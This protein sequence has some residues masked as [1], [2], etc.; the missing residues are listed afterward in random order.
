MARWKLFSKSKPKEEITEPEETVSEDLVEVEIVPEQEPEKEPL[1]EYHETLKSGVTTSEKSKSKKDRKK[2]T[3]QRIWRDVNSIE[4]KV[5]NLHITR[6]KEPVSEIDKTV[7]KI[8]S[9]GKKK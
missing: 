9:K 8:I 5:D 1:V 2:Q 4:E 7:D 3:D 6:A